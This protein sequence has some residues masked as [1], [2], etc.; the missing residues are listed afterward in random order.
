MVLQSFVFFCPVERLVAQESELVPVWHQQGFG[1]WWLNRRP[2]PICQ[3]LFVGLTDTFRHDATTTALGENAA[4]CNQS[5]DLCWECSEHRA[6]SSHQDLYT[7]HFFQG[8]QRQG[9]KARDALHL[10]LGCS[11]WALTKQ[12]NEIGD[13]PRT[14]ETNP[15]ASEQG[16]SST[17]LT[18]FCHRWTTWQPLFASETLLALCPFR[19]LPQ[20]RFSQG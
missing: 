12:G 17:H 13:Q 4:R 20:F 15:S 16:D 3:L 11:C 9:G 7:L 10:A 5:G 14:E 1:H 2:H 19:L 6:L 18:W 8:Q